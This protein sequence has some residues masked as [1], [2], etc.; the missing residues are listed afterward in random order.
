MRWVVLFS[1]G[2]DIRIREETGGQAAQAQAEGDGDGDSEEE[3]ALPGDAQTAQT[4][5]EGRPF[6]GGLQRHSCVRRGARDRQSGQ[7]TRVP[8]VRRRPH[9]QRA[10]VHRRIN[11]HCHG[12]A[13]ARACEGIQLFGL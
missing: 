4:H 2:F 10:T 12:N 8:G 5:T 6:R 11:H 13:A 1:G 3:C 7:H 9:C